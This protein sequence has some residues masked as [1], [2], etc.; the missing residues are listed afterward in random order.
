MND[1]TL[2]SVHGYAGDA[3]QIRNLMPYYLHHKRPVVVVSPVDSPIAPIHLRTQQGQVSFKYAGQREYVGHL[4]LERQ[5]QQLKLLLKIPAQFYLMN[6]SDS[7]CISSRIPDYLYQEDVFWSNEVPDV[8][9][10]MPPDWPYPRLAFQ[11]PYFC[12]R[13]ILER[14]VAA[15]EKVTF[16]SCL[17]LVF[18]DHYMM[19]LADAGQIPHKHYIRGCSC[20]TKNYPP[21][22]AVMKQLVIDGGVMLHAVKSP[23]VIQMIVTARLE[24]NR[25][26]KCNR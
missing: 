2:V 11:P 4:S 26:Q 24:H 13:R 25:Q 5:K 18:I 3:E 22:Q 9:H 14:M 17:Q 19:R 1:G 16:Q 8:M 21:G 10:T 23:D 15:T 6:D 12:S 7:V 20:P